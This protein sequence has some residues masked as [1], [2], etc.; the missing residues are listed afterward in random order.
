VSIVFMCGQALAAP[1]QADKE[2]ARTLMDQGDAQTEAK[3]YAAALKLYQAAHDLMGVPTTGLE[4]ARTQLALGQLLEARDTA[5]AVTRIPSQKHESRAFTQAR[6]E[7]QQLADSLSARIPSIQLKITGVAE[8][9]DLTVR[10]DGAD[11][12]QSAARLPR[13][14]NPGKHHIEVIAPGYQS[15]TRDVTVDEG[16]EVPTEVDLQQATTPTAATAQSPLVGSRSASPAP[17][18]T[19][20]APRRGLPT[21]S[22][23]GFGV[24]TAGLLMGSITGIM[25]MAKTSSIKNDHCGGGNDCDPK[26]QSEMDSAD[27]LSKLS[28][29]GFGVA[30]VG[31]AVG[32]TAWI[33]A[34]AAKPAQTATSKDRAVNL[35]PVVGTRGIGLLGTF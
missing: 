13:K 32:V 6:H 9:V 24:G 27:T 11:V 14:V 29:I 22:Y 19:A 28:N 31:V 17:A 18:P 1:T 7:A 15:A 26:A 10:V 5:L 23:V 12:P 8:G 21:L 20:A 34:P 35:T 2:T 16:K 3:D 25:T 30:I 33:A 4:V